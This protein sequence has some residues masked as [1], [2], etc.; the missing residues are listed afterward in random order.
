MMTALVAADC[1]LPGMQQSDDELSAFWSKID[2]TVKGAG[3]EEAKEEVFLAYPTMRWALQNPTSAQPLRQMVSDYSGWHWAHK[4]PARSPQPPAIERLENITVPALSIVGER[5]MPRYHA[6]SDLF[7]HRIPNA[8][9]VVIK[10][11]GHM[12]NMESPERFN[13]IVLGFL[14]DL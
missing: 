2:A 7:S 3:V 11:A 9:K 13:E 12:C 8:K 1:G 14:S 6:A 5:D 10:G 4:D